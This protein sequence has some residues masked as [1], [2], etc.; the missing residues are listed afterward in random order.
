MYRFCK[1]FNCIHYDED[2]PKKLCSNCKIKDYV[3]NYENGTK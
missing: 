1:D 2:K 3:R